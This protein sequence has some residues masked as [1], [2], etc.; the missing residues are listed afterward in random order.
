ML[1]DDYYHYTIE[2]STVEDYVHISKVES[3]IALKCKAYLEMRKRKEETGEGDEK[4]IRK[5]R[6]DVFRL[7]AS[8][9]SGEQ[10]F[11][12]PDKL[13][14]DV[15]VFSEMVESDLPDANLIKDMGLRRIKPI[16][17]LERLKILFVKEL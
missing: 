13:Y 4:H 9:T 12:L 17:L 1:D 11:E 7:V 2:H 16:D 8:I 10:T 14:R 3:L 5:H 6:N 15:S